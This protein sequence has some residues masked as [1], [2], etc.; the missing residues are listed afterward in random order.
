M[1]ELLRGSGQFAEEVGQ[2]GISGWYLAVPAML[3]WVPIGTH[4]MTPTQIRPGSNSAPSGKK[5]K[6]R[7]AIQPQLLPLLAWLC[8]WFVFSIFCFY[9]IPGKVKGDGSIGRVLKR[10]N[11]GSVPRTM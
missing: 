2:A 4:I 5:E 9:Q 1:T 6:P 10:E 3:C 11:P 7:V 8:G